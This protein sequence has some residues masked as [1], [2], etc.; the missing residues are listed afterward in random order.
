MVLPSMSNIEMNEL[1]KNI[2]E[3]GGCFSAH[4]VNK[5]TVKD[6]KFYILNLDYPEN[7]GSH[8]VL[9][10]LIDPKVNIFYD[11]F[12]SPPPQKV[13]E[14]LEKSSKNF[15]FN[16]LFETEQNLF[17]NLC[18]YFCVFIILLQLNS[19]SPSA[20]G[21]APKGWSPQKCLDY[22]KGDY[23][24]NENIIKRFGKI[25]RKRFL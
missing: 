12:S 8:W 5:K 24:E 18:G 21:L 9:L 10:S 6:G 2:K 3:Y 7:E 17:S 14:Y 11:S 22:F 20:S 23:K 19:L 13:Y 4:E 15:I 25:L 16:P 1:F